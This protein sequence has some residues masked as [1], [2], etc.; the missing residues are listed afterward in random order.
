MPNSYG[1][2]EVPDG[3][4]FGVY[5]L[6]NGEWVGIWFANEDDAQVKADAL[7]DDENLLVC[8]VADQDDIL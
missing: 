5:D 3:A 8:G 7:R 1:V 4:K 2:T 6:A